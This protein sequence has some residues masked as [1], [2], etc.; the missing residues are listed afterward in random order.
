MAKPHTASAAV[1]STSLQ[2]KMSHIHIHV[3][4]HTH[5]HTQTHTIETLHGLIHEHTTIMQ[6]GVYVCMHM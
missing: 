6:Q 5:T 4:L 3:H 1:A 2:P